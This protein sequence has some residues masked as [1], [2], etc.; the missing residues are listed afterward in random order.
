M[1]SRK[2]FGYLRVG[3]PTGQIKREQRRRQRYDLVTPLVYRLRRDSQWSGS[4][5]T[6]NMNTDGILMSADRD[7]AL[8]ARI[9]LSLE[10]TGL[11]HGTTRMRLL[12][13]AIVIRSAG[14]F[15]AVRIID[16]E[17]VRIGASPQ[18]VPIADALR[19]DRSEVA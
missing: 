10:W 3:S 16:H 2:R 18:I 7:F 5:S 6:V 11:Y 8:G 9:E 15:T 13:R 19:H 14:G 12:V 17:F 4:G 1:D